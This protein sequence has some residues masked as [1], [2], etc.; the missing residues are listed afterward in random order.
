MLDDFSVCA[1]HVHVHVPD[2]ETAVLA[3]NHLRPWLPLLVA[4]SANSPFH[5]GQDTGYAD[6]RSVI[7]SCF[8]C[9]GPPPY[10]ESLKH[11]EELAAAMAETEAML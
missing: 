7:R 6:W 1:V 9:L 4:L 11:H 10:A 5:H 8:P 3:G 2:R